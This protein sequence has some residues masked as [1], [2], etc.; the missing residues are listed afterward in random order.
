MSATDFI[1]QAFTTLTS[2]KNQLSLSTPIMTCF[3]KLCTQPY[4]NQFGVPTIFVNPHPRK[5]KTLISS[6]Q[7]LTKK[8]KSTNLK[9]EG[10]QTNQTYADMMPSTLTN[11][12]ISYQNRDVIITKPKTQLAQKIREDSLPV[13]F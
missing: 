12:N 9:V 8:A 4:K 1:T 7:I 13:S 5:P 3:T 2:L 6:L 10:F 11:Q